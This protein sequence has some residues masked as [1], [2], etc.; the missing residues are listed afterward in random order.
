[1]LFDYNN[2]DESETVIFDDEMISVKNEKIVIIIDNGPSRDIKLKK[3]DIVIKNEVISLNDLSCE[4]FNIFK[5]LHSCIFGSE[6]N[7]SFLS[8]DQQTLLFELSDFYRFDIVQNML[9][10]HFRN[11]T[12]GNCWALFKLAHRR[13]DESFGNV[14]AQ[15]ISQN[16]KNISDD[17]NFLD[18]DKDI[19]VNLLSRNTF[20][21]TEEKI[22]SAVLKW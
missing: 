2:S 15:F 12:E 22:F 9:S 7:F 10:N 3:E 18:L 4:Y 21:L 17:P 20:Y 5:I 14:Y 8:P 1:M 6:I 13:K 16:I 11:V 19:L